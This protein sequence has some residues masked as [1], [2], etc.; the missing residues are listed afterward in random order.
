LK[1]NKTAVYTLREADHMFGNYTLRY[2]AVILLSLLFLLAVALVFFSLF[3]MPEQ[4][5]RRSRAVMP[6]MELACGWQSIN[7]QEGN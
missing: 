7:R 1:Q 5:P 4:P 3:S 2:A 6:D